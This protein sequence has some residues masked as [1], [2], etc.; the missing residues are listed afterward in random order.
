MSAINQLTYDIGKRIFDRR[1]QLNI[2]QEQLS[3]LCDTTPQ[4][5]SNYE[6]GE[7]ELKASTIVK[8]ATAL[9]ISID[10]L[11]TGNDLTVTD[12]VTDISPEKQSLIRDI[13]NKCVELSK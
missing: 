11:L 6:R 10:Y 4:A 2:T 5:I 9:S 1:K 8:M 3:E 7:R 12:L 13:L